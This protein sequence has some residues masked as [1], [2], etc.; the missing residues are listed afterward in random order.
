M[1][2]MRYLALA[3]LG[4]F[5]ALPVA[6]VYTVGAPWIE[7][8]EV[9]NND[10]SALQGRGV[11]GTVIEVRYQQRNFRQG[12]S[13]GTPLFE[14]CGW[15]LPN[16]LP[17]G[18]A[19]VTA[20]G[21]WRLQGLDRQVLPAEVEGRTCATG[22]LTHIE[23]HSEY[24]DV[25]VPEVQNLNLP[26]GTTH[27][28]IRGAVQFA[29]QVAIGIADGPQDVQDGAN[30]GA[31]DVDEDGIDLCESGLGCGTPV[32]WSSSG[33]LFISPTIEVRDDSPLFGPRDPEFNH[34]M[35]MIQA[36]KPGGSVLAVA[37]VPRPAPPLG[38][39]LNINVDI[40]A[41]IDLD[42]GLSLCSGP[43]LFK[44]ALF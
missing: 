10:L 36:H 39:I 44:F 11:P 20:A 37:Y 12:F 30:P 9:R 1:K 4:V 19:V 14:W 6:K 7:R 33:G 26:P 22:V 28:H 24:G 8:I 43:T 34:V 25:S 42:L 41:D 23:L 27:R 16:A 17:L 35:G 13:T 5:V 31:V 2:R 40:N 3:A 15:L 29:N 18:T 38:P 32:S 21:T